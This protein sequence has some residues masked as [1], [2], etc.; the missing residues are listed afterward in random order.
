MQT[1]LNSRESARL[2]NDVKRHCSRT[3]PAVRS[4]DCGSWCLL[5]QWTHTGAEQMSMWSKSEWLQAAT[6]IVILKLPAGWVGG[7]NEIRKT[8]EAS[9]GAC[10]DATHWYGALAQRLQA[11]QLAVKI[12]GAL[13]NERKAANGH[14]QTRWERI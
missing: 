7:W 11:R 3:C 9:M 6:A 2:Y 5:Y 1:V 14:A 10:P 12:Y 13:P 8:V 4:G